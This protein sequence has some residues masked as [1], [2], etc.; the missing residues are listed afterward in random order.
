MFS[1]PKEK[2]FREYKDMTVIL[3]TH[4]ALQL[5]IPAK[6]KK[7]FKLKGGEMMTCFANKK[8]GEILYRL[9]RDEQ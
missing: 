3:T 5:H 8:T 7:R 2:D 9:V 4:G 6:V 1:L